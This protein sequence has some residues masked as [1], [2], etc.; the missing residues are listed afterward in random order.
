MG[1][2]LFGAEITLCALFLAESAEDAAREH[3]KTLTG[4]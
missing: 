2:K 4:K 3:I 1:R